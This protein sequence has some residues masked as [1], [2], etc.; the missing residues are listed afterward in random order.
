[1]LLYDHCTY[2]TCSSPTVL[3]A[4]HGEWMVS[5]MH[6]EEM[7]SYSTVHM[8]VHRVLTNYTDKLN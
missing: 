6:T 5:A 4:R 2:S 1:M 7:Q 8:Y 3:V